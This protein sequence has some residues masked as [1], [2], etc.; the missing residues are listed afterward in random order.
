MTTATILSSYVSKFQAFVEDKNRKAVKLGCPE[1]TY[2][3]SPT[4][5]V[6]RSVDGTASN[7]RTYEYVTVTVDESSIK[8]NGF[9][10]VGRIDDVEGDIVVSGMSDMKKYR[11]IAMTRCDHCNVAR[12][13]NHLIVLSDGSEDKVVGSTCLV[14]YTGHKSALS[15][16]SSL[17]WVYNLQ[18]A[19]DAEDMTAT[20]AT[21]EVLN[22]QRVLQVAAAVIRLGG[23]VSKTKAEDLGVE[24]T[25]HIVASECFNQRTNYGSD[26]ITSA[27]VDT[28]ASVLDWFSNTPHEDS[29]F[30]HNV[31]IFVGKGYVPIRFVGYVVGLL[32]WYAKSLRRTASVHSQHID[33][34]GAK[35]V[36]LQLSLVRSVV[37]GQYAYGAPTTYMYIFKSGD[38]TVVYN[39]ATMFEVGFV[40]TVEATIKDHSHYNGE[41]QTV[42]TRAKVI[43]KA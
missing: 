10:V 37:L 33:V 5:L 43:D 16:L 34:V 26:L 39:T 36:K 15:Y 14:D 12:S 9:S 27:D 7:T 17:G 13:R 20:S 30:F 25:K 4:F 40:Y 32:P 21:L 3:I 41:A 31:S 29:D 6:E 1:V 38:N 2:T 24:P 28:A 8:L 19:L 11:N 42:I 18:E 22:V 35:K 23:Y